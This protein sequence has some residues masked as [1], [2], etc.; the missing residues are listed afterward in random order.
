VTSADPQVS[1]KVIEEDADV[2]SSDG[3]VAARVSR[4]VGDHEADVFTGLAV[5]VGALGHER[6]VAAERVSGIWPDRVELSVTREEIEALPEYEDAPTVR[7]RPGALGGIFSR[8]LGG[9]R[10]P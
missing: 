3:E 10:R 9:R 8:L 6:F 5:H 7:W 4:I 2:V 1:W